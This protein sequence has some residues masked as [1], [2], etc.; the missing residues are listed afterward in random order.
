MI[1]N[2]NF[3]NSLLTLI[4]IEYNSSMGGQAVT[5]DDLESP[6][7]LYWINAFGNMNN[8][9]VFAT[10]TFRVKS[11]A[12][13]GATAEI[14]VSYDSDDIYNINEENVEFFVEN[15]VITVADGV[16]GDI[17]GD[18]ELN[19]KDVTRL[20]QYLAGWDVVVNDEALDV[21]GDG[22]VNNKDV[23][24]LMQFLA[25]WDVEIY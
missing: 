14:S 16:C 12:T 15:G 6:L 11:D 25:D 4:S 17:N 21:N 3:D 8:D 7:T 22:V 23:T 9:V 2:V 10:L 1:L 19:N 18:G 5:P 20:M 24:R 13:A